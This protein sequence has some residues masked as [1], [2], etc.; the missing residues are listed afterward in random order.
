MKS[1]ENVLISGILAYETM[2]QTKDEKFTQFK[3]SF[4]FLLNHL[5]FE[6]K[7]PKTLSLVKPKKAKQKTS[8]A[9]SFPPMNQAR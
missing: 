9:N 7:P 1:S 6:L 4:H 2:R 3:Q 8:M 5:D